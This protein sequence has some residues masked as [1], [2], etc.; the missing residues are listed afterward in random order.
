MAGHLQ[1]LPPAG[2]RRERRRPPAWLDLRRSR[3]QTPRFVRQGGSPPPPRSSSNGT[4][5]SFRKALGGDDGTDTTD[6]RPAD[7][8]G[9]RERPSPS[10][11]E[12]GG[13]IPAVEGEWGELMMRGQDMHSVLIRESRRIEWEITTRDTRARESAGD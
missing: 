2:A 7:G 9:N 13:A 8:G 1:S 10:T 4:G 5:G 3:V 6:E 11:D 12:P